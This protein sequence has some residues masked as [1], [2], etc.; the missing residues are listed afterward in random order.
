MGKS[1]QNRGVEGWIEWEIKLSLLSSTRALTYLWFVPIDLPLQKD[2]PCPICYMSC[3][4]WSWGV[5][6]SR[7]EVC[8]RITW[9]FGLVRWLTPR[10]GV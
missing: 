6:G 3:W 9:E 10:N 7:V 2:L 5:V 4:R 1:I 8:S